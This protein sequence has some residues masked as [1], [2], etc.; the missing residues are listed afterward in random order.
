MTGTSI[1]RS[2]LATIVPSEF[3][4]ISS[5][6][7]IPSAFSIFEMIFIS[8]PPFSSRKFLISLRFSLFL[9][10]E[11]AIKSKPCSIQNLISSL[12]FSLIP[13]RRILI[14]GRFMCLLE[15]ITQSLRAS[16]LRKSELF[17]ITLTLK[18]HESITISSPTCKSSTR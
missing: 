9:M 10:K 14:P 7:F 2:H 4:I 11:A 16:T 1:Q 17:S 12:S 5:I 15:P 18:S 3:F 13:G 6:F 8:F